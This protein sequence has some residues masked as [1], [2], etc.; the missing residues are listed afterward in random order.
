[1]L[2]TRAI[3]AVFALLACA[4]EVATASRLPSSA[5][6]NTYSSSSEAAGTNARVSSTASQSPGLPTGLGSASA[7]S[8]SPKNADVQVPV[9]TSLALAASASDA[10]SEPVTGSL[11]GSITTTPAQAAQYAV[12]DLENAPVEQVANA[13]LDDHK[14][15]FMPYVSTMTVGGTLTYVNSEPFP[16]TAFSMK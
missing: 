11:S 14:M 12:V 2:S 3:L 8:A 1:M 7:V 5:Q 16:D 13:R 15:T 9:N 6:N 10:G 4:G